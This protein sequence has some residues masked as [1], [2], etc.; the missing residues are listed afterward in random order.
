MTQQKKKKVRVIL[1]TNVSSSE[2]HHRLSSPLILFCPL[3][4]SSHIFIFHLI[5]NNYFY[6]SQATR[7]VYISFEQN[8]NSISSWSMLNILFY[9]GINSMFMIAFGGPIITKGGQV[10][11]PRLPLN[12]EVPILIGHHLLS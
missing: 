4:F 5:F 2:F 10:L 9:L 6:R 11:V 1:E 3:F 12:P 8:I 7:N